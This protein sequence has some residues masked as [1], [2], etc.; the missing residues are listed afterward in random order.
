MK[1]YDKTVFGL[2]PV[3]DWFQEKI[4]RF[5]DH[6]CSES[7]KEGKKLENPGDQWGRINGCETDGSRGIK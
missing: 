1:V 7:E 4:F 6:L 3:D 5:T 2:N